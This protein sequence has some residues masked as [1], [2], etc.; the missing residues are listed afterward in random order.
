[1]TI[2]LVPEFASS[3][4]VCMYL[5]TFHYFAV[6]IGSVSS[7]PLYGYPSPPLHVFV[8]PLDE[9]KKIWAQGYRYIHVHACTYMYHIDL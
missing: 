4:Y 6:A 9:D 1:M 2:N 3:L 5:N 7:V 8:L